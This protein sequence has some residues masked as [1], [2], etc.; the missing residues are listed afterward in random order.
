[1]IILKEKA[2]ICI[3]ALL[4]FSSLLSFGQMH[5]LNEKFELP[6]AV[7]ETSGLIF[8]NNHLITHNDSG[9]AANLFEIDTL[10]GTITRTITI[11]NATNIDWEDIS[12]D[13]THIFI[14]DIGNNNGNRQDLKVYKILKSDF[15]NSTN[16]TA[17]IISF[18]YADQT[19]FS[20]Q[21]NNTKFDAE[22]IAVF[23]ENIVIFTKN[24]V[25]FQTS[26]YV[27]PKTTGTHTAQKVSSYDSQGL[28]TGADF[29]G[30]RIML[31]G[32]NSV[33]MPF[34][35]FVHE[36]RPPGLDFFA[37]NPFRIDLVNLGLLEQGSQIE[38]I[39]YFD[40]NRV[41]ITREFSSFDAGTTTIEF[42]Q[43]LYEFTSG[44]FGLLSI[45]DEEIAALFEL[46]PNPTSTSFSV[47]QKQNEETIE[48]V[49]L[50]D[51]RG[52]EVMTATKKSV[53]I[54]HLQSGI[55]L[56]RI[57]L[58]SKKSVIKKLVIE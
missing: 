46:G 14:G 51:M 19:D 6:A 39:G 5:Q 50:Y 55:Y 27:I 30:D 25:D 11:D 17:E 31:S 8:Y 49:S 44:L 48:R 28:I 53:D 24:W 13:D 34:L 15:D 57:E 47:I 16:V 58:Q 12:Q 38:A 21:P 36:N 3:G 56:V 7:E 43:K 23:Q 22:A 52:T 1:M 41:Y 40:F 33:G 18:S 45:H 4:F 42:P 26:A 37:G 20:S 35:V 32:Y 29:Q 10:S 54:S 2:S 9:N